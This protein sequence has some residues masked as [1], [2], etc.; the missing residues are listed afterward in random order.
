MRDSRLRVNVFLTPEFADQFRAVA[1]Q[2]KMSLTNLGS[3]C[4]Q[5]GFSALQMAGNKEF[6][7]YFENAI[8]EIEENDAKKK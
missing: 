7:P 2:N 1:D 6:K 5:L 3:I 4:I 8:K